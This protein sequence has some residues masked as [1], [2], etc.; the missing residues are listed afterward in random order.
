LINNVYCPV[1]ESKGRIKKIAR[2]DEHSKGK[3]YLWCK[4]CKQE[5]E[6]ILNNEPMRADSKKRY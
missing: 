5:V 3:I 1:C 2:V 6:V 4:N